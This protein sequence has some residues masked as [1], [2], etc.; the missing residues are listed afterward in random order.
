[1]VSITLGGAAVP[2]RYV[3]SRRSRRWVAW[4]HDPIRADHLYD[5]QEEAE[6]EAMLLFAANRAELDGIEVQEYK[7]GVAGKA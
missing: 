1:M 3:W 2:I 7:V 6:S 5:S 4:V